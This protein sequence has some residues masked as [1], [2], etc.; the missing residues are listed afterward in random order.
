MSDQKGFNNVE[1]FSNR[2]EEVTFN[3]N[4]KETLLKIQKATVLVKTKKKNESHKYCCLLI[5]LID[6]DI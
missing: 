6:A 1:K 3:T 5:Q 2:T 4:E